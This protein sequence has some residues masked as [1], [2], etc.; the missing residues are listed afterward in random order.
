MKRFT[1]FLCVAL[2]VSLA[3]PAVADDLPNYMKSGAP[4]LIGGSQQ[5]ALAKAGR[6]TAILIGP[7]GSGA[8]ANGQ[9][10]DDR[11]QPD[12]NGWTHYDVTQPTE[13]HWQ[14]SDYNADGLGVAPG[15]GN[16]AAWCGDISFEACSEEDPEG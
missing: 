8:Q 9:F 1:M 4:S 2:A 7:W 13:T 10:Q 14:L 15:A 12:W 6:D 5:Q 16:M 3:V 11:G